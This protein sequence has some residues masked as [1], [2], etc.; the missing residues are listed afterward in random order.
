MN[1]WCSGVGVGVSWRSDSNASLSVF[2][3]AWRRM[4]A[5]LPNPSPGTW[6]DVPAAVSSGIPIVSPRVSSSLVGVLHL[7]VPISEDV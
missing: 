6:V 7:S 4:G 3:V 1:T 5:F 2:K